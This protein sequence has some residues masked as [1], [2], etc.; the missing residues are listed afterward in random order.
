MLLLT[1]FFSCSSK[2]SN[3]LSQAAEEPIEGNPII[4]DKY[5]ADPAAIVFN[6][7]VF[8]YVGHDQTE[9]R[10]YRYSLQEWLIY[11][12][13]D[14]VNWTEHPVPLSTKAFKWARGSAWASQV[15]AK[16]GKFYWYVTVSHD[17]IHGKA[18][19]VA[20]ADRPTGPFKDARGSAIITNNMTTNVSISW[21]DIDPTF[22]FD[23][24]GQGYL[25]WGNTSCR[26]VRMKENMIEFDGDIQYIDLPNFTEAP[27]IHKRGEWYYLSYAYKFPEKTAYAMSK[28]L[29]GPWVFRGIINEVAGNSNTNHQCIIEYK[30]KWY[31]IYHNGS[32]PIDGGSFR[33]SVCIDYLYYNPDGTIKRIVMTTEGVNPV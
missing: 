15:V 16:E 29:E 18:I 2:N 4:R 8:L 11:Y 17:S 3:D 23:E 9:P 7:T 24:Q 10:T 28:N 20:V 25:Y 19:G 12:S 33:R 31:F 32:L 22:F 27:F 5:T 13:T 14:M 1:G 30:G 26:F 6:D 21:D